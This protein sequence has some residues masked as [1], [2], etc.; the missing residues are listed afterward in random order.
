MPNKSGLPNLLEISNKFEDPELPSILRPK[1]IQLKNAI[2]LQKENDL[3]CVD[4]HLYI[5]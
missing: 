5:S 4:Q 3:K 1:P 2:P